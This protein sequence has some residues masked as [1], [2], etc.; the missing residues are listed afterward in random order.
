[1]DINGFPAWV[2]RLV[3]YLNVPCW[4]G[5]QSRTGLTARSCHI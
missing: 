3:K 5:T 2:G 4:A 1:M